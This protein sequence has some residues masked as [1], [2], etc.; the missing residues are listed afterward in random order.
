MSARHDIDE[1]WAE[2]P[3]TLLEFRDTSLRIDLREPV[4]QFHL[5]TLRDLGLDRPFAVLTAENPW[6]ENVEDEPTENQ[7]RERQAENARRSRDLERELADAGTFFRRVD[8]VAPDGEYREHL[9]A[10]TLDRNAAVTLARRL[11]QLA[12]FWFD[13]DSFWLVPALAEKAA[14]R[15]P[16]GR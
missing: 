13:G 1:K 3:C 9:R 2:Y 16:S 11:R 4:S 12:I 7:Q 15:L 8:G 10:A 5:D 6:G 14:E